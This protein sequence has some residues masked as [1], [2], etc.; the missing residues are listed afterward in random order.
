MAERLDAQLE[1]Q[2]RRFLSDRSRNRLVG[3]SLEVSKIFDWF[4]D[5]FEAAGGVESFLRR[6]REQIKDAVRRAI[7]GRGI[8]DI[9]RTTSRLSQ[10]SGNARDLQSLSISL[11]HIPALKQD[12][13]SLSHSSINDLQSSILPRLH[14]FHE[15]TEMLSQALTDE[16][17]AHL[18]DGG[19]IRDGWSPALDELRDAS[20]G[21]KDWIAR[22]QE[23]ERKRTGIDSLR[24]QVRRPVMEADDADDNTPA[25][26]RHALLPLDHARRAWTV[27]EPIS[28]TAQP[29]FGRFTHA[30]TRKV[31]DPL[32]APSASQASKN[33]SLGTAKTSESRRA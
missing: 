6:Y 3:A 30:P 13:S 25:A 2:T 1:E 4:G 12:L 24:S 21:G 15:L 20:R 23:D 33:T 17:P 18:R 29:A 14:E 31:H 5:D 9:E 10:N 28:S 22:L 8:R 11:S 32:T 26:W 19:V 27:A 16:P 7:D